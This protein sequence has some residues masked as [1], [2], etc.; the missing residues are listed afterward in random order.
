MY[1]PIKNNRLFIKWNDPPKRKP[2]DRVTSKKSKKPSDKS[3]NNPP[4]W[5]IQRTTV[6]LDIKSLKL[7]VHKICRNSKHL[8]SSAD[9]YVHHIIFLWV[10][11]RAVN[12]LIQRSCLCLHSLWLILHQRGKEPICSQI[13]RHQRVTKKPIRV[14][15][16]QSRDEVD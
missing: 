11:D 3:N 4:R 9:I 10:N 14:Q 16:F 15:L 6:S 5:T 12:M 7:H 8:Q 13:Q 2:T 1:I